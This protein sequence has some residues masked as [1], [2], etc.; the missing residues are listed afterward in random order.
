[1]NQNRSQRKIIREKKVL[2]LF[3]P[4]VRRR[5]QVTAITVVDVDNLTDNLANVD[6]LNNL[7][8]KD[9]V[10]NPNPKKVVDIINPYIHV[11]DTNIAP[12]TIIEN[13]KSEVTSVNSNGNNSNSSNNVN[14]NTSLVIIESKKKVNN[15]KLSAD[16][17]VNTNLDLINDLNI[18]NN[19][20]FN[21][22]V[23]QKDNKNATLNKI[24]KASSIIP[25]K[26]LEQVR[27]ELIENKIKNGNGNIN[28]NSNSRLQLTQQLTQ[29]LTHQFQLE[30]QAQD[31]ISAQAIKVETVNGEVDWAAQQTEMLNSNGVIYFDMFSDIYLTGLKNGFNFYQCRGWLQQDTG[32]KTRDLTI[33]LASNNDYNF[34]FEVRILDKDSDD[35]IECFP[36]INMLVTIDKNGKVDYKYHNPKILKD[37]SYVEID[38]SEYNNQ[39]QTI[40]PKISYISN[41]KQDN[42]KSWVGILISR[43]Q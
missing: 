1:M 40:T 12:N 22:L 37:V 13:K 21:L 7:K 20:I 41:K 17:G 39:D 9:I 11:N 42:I 2:E 27:K 25:D 35:L 32:E 10:S 34:N 8:D 30:Q 18:N 38:C 3:A 15:N 43:Y 28:S 19:S 24:L 29:Q 31:N 4:K 14:V 36:N 26:K 23:D 5:N 16:T 33:Y 6:E